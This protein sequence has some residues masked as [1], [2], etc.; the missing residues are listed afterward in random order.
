VEIPAEVRIKAT[1]RPGSVYYFSAYE[2]STDEPHYFIVINRN[3]LTDEVLLLVWAS[4][5]VEKVR[6]RRANQP[7]TLV[8]IEPAQYPAFSRT[9]VI[10]CNNVLKKS[11][12]EIVLRLNCGQLKVKPDM[13]LSLIEQIREALRRSPIIDRE[14]IAILG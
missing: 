12:D 14:T 8:E 3:P 6:R 7:G 1:V 11:L 5:Q 13:P 4:S 10:D 2:F 9:S